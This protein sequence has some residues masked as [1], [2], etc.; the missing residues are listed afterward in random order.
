V[1]GG[2]APAY[3]DLR[4]LPYTRMV[5]EESMRLYPPAWAVGRYAIE[6]RTR[7]AAFAFQRRRSC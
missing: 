2:R 4:A 1:L 7:S 5:L 3:E 6:K